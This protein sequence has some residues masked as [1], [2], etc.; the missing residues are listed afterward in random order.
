MAAITIAS[1]GLL[2][3]YLT[4]IVWTS[5][6]C[7]NCQKTHR[8]SSFQNNNIIC[9]LT[10]KYTVYFSARKRFISELSSW[11]NPA[12]FRHAFLSQHLLLRLRPTPHPLPSPTPPPH[13]LPSTTPAATAGRG[14]L[15]VFQAFADS[16]Y[17]VLGES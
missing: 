7:Y 6:Y 5:K 14:R 3:F 15:S 13:P 8:P 16:R 11:Q 2:N 4:H 17:D 12:S 1:L 9:L 10:A